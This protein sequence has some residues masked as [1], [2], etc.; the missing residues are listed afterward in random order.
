MRFNVSSQLNYHVKFPSTLILNIQAQMSSAQYV[1]EEKLTTNP[2]VNYEE[3]Y[4]EA[5]SSRFIRLQ[6]GNAQTLE[7]CYS[8]TVDCSTELVPAKGAPPVSIAEM[9]R[10]AI[11]YLFPSRYVQSDRLSKLAWDLFGK[12]NDPYQKVVA[13][14]DWIYSN[15]EYALGS[16]D[17]QT[18]AY[19]TVVERRGVCRDFAHLGIAYCRALNI[20][21][22]YFSG[23]AYQLNPPDFHALFECYVAGQWLL[24]DSTRLAPLNGLVR[25]GT[26][27]DAADAALA[28]IFG[29][30][31]GTGVKV[32]CQ[33]GSGET[34]T[35]LFRNQLRTQGIAQN[36]GDSSGNG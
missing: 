9:D 14:D 10:N 34:F 1:V 28:S 29:G 17:S 15:I 3:F 5:G 31:Q 27:R 13:I 30:V 33:L 4:L 16:T 21:A 20:P 22:R 18:S 6:T 7:I 2:Q 25:I 26:G 36:S 8:A 19:D 23:Y 12:I 32:D 35:P 24:F 11:P